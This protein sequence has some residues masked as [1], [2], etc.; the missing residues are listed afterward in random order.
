MDR[1]E[2]KREIIRMY[3]NCGSYIL[4]VGKK[5]KNGVFATLF[6]HPTRNQI[7]EVWESVKKVL[8]VFVYND[9][10]NATQ[11]K[12]IECKTID[13]FVKAIA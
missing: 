1:N 11:R 4:E 9:T 6:H 12:S 10:T 3:A 13:D 2:L 5:E 8:T 7:I